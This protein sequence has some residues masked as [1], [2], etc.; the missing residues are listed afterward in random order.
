MAQTAAPLMNARMGPSAIQRQGGIAPRHAVEQRRGE[1]GHVRG[2]EVRHQE[3][4]RIDGAGIEGQQQ[5][6]RQV[7]RG[8]PVADGELAD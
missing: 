6:E 5:A 8:R 1:A 3:A 2:V 4:A 7:R